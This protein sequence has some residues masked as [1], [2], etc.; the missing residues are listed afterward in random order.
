[1]A[2]LRRVRLSD[3]NVGE[4]DEDDEASGNGPVNVLVVVPEGEVA[5]PR[6]SSD[7]QELMEKAVTTAL[8]TRDNKR[9]VCS[10]P[11]L[12]PEHKER[13]AKKMRLADD[14]YI[15]IDE[16]PNTLI[17]G[18]TWLNVPEDAD[19]QRAGYMA[20]LEVHFQ[21]V[22]KEEKLSWLDVAKN[23]TVLSVRDPRLP[24][25]MSGTA[26]VLLVDRRSTQHLEPL[27]GVRMVVELKKKVEERHKPKHSENCRCLCLLTCIRKSAAEGRPGRVLRA[28][29]L[30]SSGRYFPG[31]GKSCKTGNLINVALEN[32]G[33]GVGP[34]EEEGDVDMADAES[35]DNGNDGDED[36]GGQDARSA[37]EMDD[38]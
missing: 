3:E 29:H 12:Q 13:M 2:G 31:T 30:Y 15:I 25:E 7:L 10:L 23:E 9:S 32:T 37:V 8:E 19:D 20:Y 21:R 5:A 22:L 17:P 35:D 38:S 14:D 11:E 27:A 28:I 34:E 4:V 6:D 24:F 1:M 26:D 16:P 18:Y 33:A 36:M